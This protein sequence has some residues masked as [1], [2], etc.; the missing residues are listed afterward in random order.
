MVD[1]ATQTDVA[2][3]R[4]ALNLLV[5]PGS[6]FEI[7]ALKIPGR[8][9]PHNAAGYFTDLDTAVRM[10][11]ALDKRKPA[12]IYLVLNEINPALLG[13][14]PNRI[15][16]YPESTTSDNDII[17]RRWLPLD[18]DAVRPAG[19][20]ATEDEHCAAED[21]GRQ[22][23]A[24]L[25][26]RG[27]P[28]PIQADSGNGWHVLYQIDLPNDEST[29]ALVRGV[30]EAVS[31]RF[32][33]QDVDVDRT[34]F[35]AARIWKLY[36]T[37]ARKGHNMAERPHRVA[38]LVEVPDLVT[39]VPIEKLEA[40]AAL[41]KPEP[42]RSSTRSNDKGASFTSK[43]DVPRWLTARGVTFKTKDR[44]DS[45]GRVVF[46]LAQCPFDPN[47]GGGGEVSVMQAPDGKMSAT[48]MHNGCTGRGWQDFKTVIGPPD[49][50]HYNP[51]LN[52][53][54]AA[55]PQAAATLESGTRVYAGDRGN[56]GT[57][58][59]DHG[60]TCTVH[61]VSPEG[62][63]AEKDLPR[64]QLRSLDGQPVDG[65]S[66]EPLPPPYSLRELVAAYPKQRK[67]V[68]E[69]LLRSGETMNIV[70]APKKGKS[71][72]ANSLG[73]SVAAGCDW[74]DTFRCTQGRVL[75]LDAELHP[76]VIAHR[77]PVVADAMGLGS[78]VFDFIDVLPLRGFGAD[79][80]RLKP[81]IDSFESGRYGLIILDAWYRFLPQGFS[82]NDNAQVMALYNMIDR[83]TATMNAAWVNIHHASKGDQSGKSTTDVG[84]GAGSQSRAAD[85]HLIIRQHEQ[86]DVAVIEAVVR[87]W[88]P[89]DRFA[90]RWG[91]PIWDRDDQADPRKLWGASNARERQA[92]EN[93]DI[94]LKED[95]Q[96]IVSAMVAHSG[97]QTKTFVRDSTRLG[98]PRFGYA[99]TS[100]ITDNTLTAVGKVKKG[101]GQSYESFV[102]SASEAEE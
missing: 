65:E 5:V 20:S 92:R 56:I 9:K 45:L 84:S 101:N 79:L 83:Y 76:E 37:T 29:A 100:L 28:E 46:I 40:L 95:R 12:G 52:R 69:G 18:F 15:T 82:E 42:S 13:R 35:N 58:V 41:L 80:V 88:P 25:S 22:C 19:I 55:K 87:S 8:G 75:L 16:D 23:S 51:P 70:A 33:G 21:V 67:S 96:A 71:W 54:N 89:V 94:H 47:H 61:F 49:A 64:S 63:H 81:L 59:A 27:W 30:I 60:D 73:L 97:P 91:F 4:R 66:A 43:L 53:N 86:D 6:A 85:T 11:W 44:P 3:L 68:I 10:V 1:N 31:Q 78:E 2:E 98:N 74:L 99:W 48:C 32:G 26:S 50:D 38:R 93:K 7:R 77:L 62:Q 34:V 17:R 39:V 14:S 102:L 90:I 24:W 36:G 72:L 57:I